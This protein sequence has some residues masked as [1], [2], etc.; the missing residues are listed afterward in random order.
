MFLMYLHYYFYYYFIISIYQA[1]VC[2]FK[3]KSSNLILKLKKRKTKICEL[4]KITSLNPHPLH[5]PL[6]GYL[7]CFFFD[8][9]NVCK[10]CDQK[11]LVVKSSNQNDTGSK[12]A[13][14][15]IND[16]IIQKGCRKSDVIKIG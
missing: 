14:I 12:K 2:I 8:E 11:T 7:L 15:C 9:K 10:T 1:C 3:I 5:Y 13:K 4:Y 16:V 6:S